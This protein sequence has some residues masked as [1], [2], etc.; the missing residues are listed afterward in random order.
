MQ[1]LL[2]A[3]LSFIVTRQT[4]ADMLTVHHNQME[5]L[6]T[7][8]LAAHQTAILRE[9]A[10]VLVNQGLNNDFEKA[11]GAGNKDGPPTTLA[12]I[13]YH[14]HSHSAVFGTHHNILQYCQE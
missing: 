4:L 7:T 10:A 8:R 14:T 13:V 6:I 9:A 5:T 3:P 2:K 12:H 11:Q 1:S